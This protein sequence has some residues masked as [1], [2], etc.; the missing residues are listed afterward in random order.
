MDNIVAK[1]SIRPELQ[2]VYF[3][4]D[5]MVATDSFRLIEVK[6]PIGLAGE[7]RVIKAK[8]FK[9]RGAVANAENDIIADGAKLIQGERVAAAYPEYERVFDGLSDEPRFSMVVNAKYLAELVAEVDAQA[10]SPFH[11]IRLD[12]FDS[13]KPLLI[14]ATGEAADNEPVS[15][16]ALLS[17]MT[18]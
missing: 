9:G 5:K 3:S 13:L 17:P 8:G 1:S 10:G 4:R 7:L 15:V 12:F 16:R 6:K 2:G 18:N 11:K 14:T